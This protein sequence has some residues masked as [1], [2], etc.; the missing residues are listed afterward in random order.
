MRLFIAVDLEPEKEYFLGIRDKIDRSLFSGS[1]PKT[2]HI[3]LKFLGEVDDGALDEIK[4][5]L[6]YVRFRPF[7]AGFDCVGHFPGGRDIRVIWCG[8]SDSREITELADK[9]DQ[10]LGDMFEH[11]K[12]FHPHVTLARVKKVNDRNALLGNI[13]N[14]KLE[15]KRVEAR[16]IKLIRSTLRPKG[17]SYETLLEVKL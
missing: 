5:R 6:S 3:T 10:A 4:E 7:T 14:I 2:F 9:V 15:K 13:K 11:D 17:P 8:M 16:S 12:R 1:F